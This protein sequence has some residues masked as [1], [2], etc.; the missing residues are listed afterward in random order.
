MDRP[1]FPLPGGDL[2]IEPF[3]IV[4]D[5]PQRAVY[6]MSRRTIIHV[7][8]DLLCVF[9]IFP[10]FHHNSRFRTPESI[11]GLIV[12][13]YHEQI[14][15]RRR[16]HT[17][18]IILSLVHILELIHQDITEPL[19]P[20]L[21]YI[22]SLKKQPPAVKNHIFKVDLA[23]PLL[24]LFICQIQ[25]PEPGRSVTQ[26][27]VCTNLITII[28]Y[29]SYLNSQFLKKILLFFGILYFFP[30]HPRRYP[31]KQFKLLTLRQQIA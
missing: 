11:D 30:V 4:G 25:L 12:V 8:Q 7:Q 18:H 27:F 22:R 6:H 3:L 26:R 16:Q 10:E 9:I 13:S 23:K 1:A 5:N 19:L 21:Q 14:I 29:I 15:F 2:L 20:L 17:H 24:L 31:A 28:L